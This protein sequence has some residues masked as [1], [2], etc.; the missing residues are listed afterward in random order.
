MFLRKMSSKCLPS[1]RTYRPW[2][3][4]VRLVPVCSGYCSSWCPGFHSLFRSLYPDFCWRALIPIL[5]R[6]GRAK[7]LTA[8]G[9]FE[10][11]AWL[12]SWQLLRSMGRSRPETGLK[13]F[14]EQLKTFWRKG[15]WLYGG[16]DSPV[17]EGL[18]QGTQCWLFPAPSPSLSTAGESLWAAATPDG[19]LRPCYP[20]N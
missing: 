3:H 20:C 17:W 1:I 15:G 6:H 7:W 4:G 2:N 16:A 18:S 11:L 19:H 12:Y 5:T 14:E 8:P 9:I 10:S 13:A